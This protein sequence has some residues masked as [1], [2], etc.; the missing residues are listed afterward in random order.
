MPR[1]TRKHPIL[2]IGTLLGLSICGVG[3]SQVFDGL[4]GLAQAQTQQQQ[5]EEERRRGR[6]NQQQ[7][8][9]GGGG[10]QQQRQERQERGQDGGQQRL[11]QQQG[12]DGGQERSRQ[13]QGNDGGQE[14]LRQQQGNDGG[15]ERSRRQQ[16]GDDG[17]QDRL[18]RQQQDGERDRAR[19]EE[20]RN[21]QLRQNAD[22]DRDK[23]RREAEE[24]RAKK[25]EQ[26]NQQL[27]QNA[28]QD[29]EKRRREAEEE[30]AKKEQ[31]RNQQLRQNAD[32]DRKLPDGQGQGQDGRQIGG[33]QPDGDSVRKRIGRGDRPEDRK[34]LEEDRQRFQ[35]FEKR[36][37]TREERQE[38]RRDRQEFTKENLKDVSKE[39]RR[40]EENGRV[41]IEEPG[42]RVI[43]KQNNKVIIRHD[44][45]D[46]IKGISR[47]VRVERGEGGRSRTVITRDNGM[48]IITI[49]DRDGHLVK[50]IKRFPDG[51]EIV[52]INND[53]EGRRRRG[54]D[55][56]GDGDRDRYRGP[57]EVFIELPEID[58]DYG[59]SDY[60]A[61]YEGSGEDEIYEV[62]TAPPVEEFAEDY[63]LDEIRYNRSIRQRLRKVNVNTVNFESGSWALSEDQVQRLS[64]LAKVINRVLTEDPEEVFLITGHTDAVGSDEDNLSL[65]D[66]R[67]ETVA[68]IL[69]DEFGV[70]AENLVTQGYGETDLRVQ[71]GGDEVRNRRVEVMRITP[72]LAREE[73][74][75]TARQ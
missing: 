16:Q 67:A 30:R 38:R 19:Q 62:L 9:G 49:K 15:Q 68:R 43:I 34:R 28:D 41:V 29:R 71:T 31:Q 57:V 46:R 74:G 2:A 56:D 3:G 51:H 22:Q 70:P 69:S 24:E 25:E 64:L 36:E 35:R 18:R 7:D 32:Q 47:D 5:E 27:R 1:T 42:D 4:T 50:R 72:A 26:R 12:N 73:S 8:G 40:R 75:G 60:Y 65:S 59:S 21:Q 37:V 54:R 13:Q 52:L 61:S 17:G 6:R 48:Q 14:R 63:T 45:T 66:R 23:R 20:Q 10:Q 58:V 39:R 11:R 44:E 55:R 53:F 33:G